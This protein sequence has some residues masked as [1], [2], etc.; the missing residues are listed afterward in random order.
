MKKIL[1]FV[2]AAMMVTAISTTAFAA[3]LNQGSDPK[4]QDTKITTSIAPTYVVTIP[5]D[6][7][8]DFNAASTTLGTVNATHMQIEPDK[9]VT[10]TAAAGKLE[11]QTDTTKTIEYKLMNGE[12]EFTSMDLIDTEK[13]AD[14]AI[15]IAED[16]WNTAYAGDYKGTITFTISYTNLIK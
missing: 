5:A 1:S 6:A 16:D 8:I 12:T 10:V 14:L 11:N 3:E 2:L 13:K 4:T 7:K 15:A 9:K